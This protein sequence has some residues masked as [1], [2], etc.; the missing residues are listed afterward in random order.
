MIRRVGGP[1]DSPS[2]RSGLDRSRSPSSSHRRAPSEFASNVVAI[3]RGS[4]LDAL[5]LHSSLVYDTKHS[6]NE[7]SELGPQAATVSPAILLHALTDNAT[8]DVGALEGAMAYEACQVEA[9]GS[10][11]ARLDC[12]ADKAFA[13]LGAM[14]ASR[15]EGVVSV[16]LC[17]ENLASLSDEDAAEA[18]VAKA[19]RMRSMFEEIGVDPE[20]VLLKIPATWAGIQAVATLEREMRVRCHVTQ[21]YCLEQAALAVDAGATL[22]QT[23]VGRVRVWYKNHPV[24]AVHNNLA[25][26]PDAGVELARQIYALTKQKCGG[27]DEAKRAKVIA[28]SVK[29]KHDA[30]LLAGCDFVLLND[31]VINNLNATLANGEK[32]I[33]DAFASATCPAVAEPLTR[34]KF[35]KALERSPAKEEMAYALKNAAAADARLKEWIKEAV[36]SGV[37]Q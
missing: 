23:Y 14:M 37:G 15:V 8:S 33:V 11:E 34:E 22:I 12:V 30:T 7:F 24:N 16:E 29:T 21:V 10:E 6:V 9:L 18:F 1:Y 5:K 4:E 35:E 17:V 25:D 26:A 20:R 32:P 36:P 27:G 31:R 19:L 2:L 13:N 3:Q 28:A